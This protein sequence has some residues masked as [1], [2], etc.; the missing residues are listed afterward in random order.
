MVGD[1]VKYV[2][3]LRELLGMSN[4]FCQRHRLSLK[5][6]GIATVMFSGYATAQDPLGRLHPVEERVVLNGPVVVVDRNNRVPADLLERWKRIENLPETQVIG[7]LD[8]PRE[9]VFGQITDIAVRNDGA[10]MVL[11][12]RAGSVKVF[13]GNGSFIESIGRPGRGPGEFL[14]PTAI[15]ISD[16]SNE[17]FVIDKARLVS[18]FELVE[19]SYRFSKRWR[20]PSAPNQ[21]CVSGTS[22]VVS[23]LTSDFSSPIRVFD[24]SGSELA[25]IPASYFSPKAP[26]QREANRGELLCGIGSIFYAS[27][28]FGDIRRYELFSQEP[29]WIAR[30]DGYRPTELR[31]N[32]AGGITVRTLPEGTHRFLNVVEVDSTAMIVQIGEQTVAGHDRDLPYVSI[33]SYLL[34]KRTG[35]GGRLQRDLPEVV[36]AAED[37]WLEVRRLPF[38]QVIVHGA[39]DSDGSG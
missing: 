8:G 19:G 12:G 27:Y 35:V 2:P 3:R 33:E 26:I 23:M 18:V 38:P 13:R 20:F 1:S 14:D 37:Y 21:V 36:K 16:N 11:D 25:Q 10:I 15:A 5:M 17:L 32:N 4:S 28:L 9:R 22:V 6:C 29:A 31:E 34:N 7:Q 30:F 24:R 39:M